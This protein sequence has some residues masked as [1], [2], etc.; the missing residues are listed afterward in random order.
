MFGRIFVYKLKEIIR[1]RYMVGWNFLFPLVLA[2]VFYLGFGNLIKD[3]PDNFNTIEA[4]YVNTNSEESSFKD[5]LDELTKETAD[6]VAVLSLHEYQ[7]KDDAITAMNG[8]EISGF[9][10]EKNNDI[11]TFVIKNGYEA[12]TLNQIVREYDNKVD[13]ITAIMEDHPEN[14]NTAIDMIK[15]DLSIM[16]Q[17]DFGN[18]TS[19]YIQYFFALIAMSSLFSSWISTALLEGM[20][21]NMTEQGKRFECA[22]TNKLMAITAGILAGLLLQTVSN[23]IVVIYVNKILGIS[24]GAPL[25]NIFMI[26]T[27]G[28]GLGISFGVLM[29]SFIKNARLL[30]AVPLCFTMGCSFCSGLMW[31]QIRQVIESNC[32]IINRINPAALLTDCLFTRATYG[33]TDVYYQDIYTMLGMIVICLVISSLCLRRRTYVSI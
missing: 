26:T 18:N 21:A 11:E 9:Y 16:E 3:D 20:C 27:I 8:G 24:F 17:Y 6:N 15:D 31:H 29:G 25:L 32:P 7:S 4:G 5:V 28:S 23:A 30:I 10:L 19:P 22:P 13:V 14:I 1:N 2:T 12:T 33:K